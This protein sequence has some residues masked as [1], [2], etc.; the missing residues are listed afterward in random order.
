MPKKYTDYI[1]CNRLSPYQNIS[2]CSNEELLKKLIDN[3]N[4]NEWSRNAALKSLLGLVALDKLKRDEL[5]DYIRMLFH[6][7]LA[8]DEDFLTRLV[9]TASDIYPEELMQEINK[10]FE[11]NKVDTFCVDKAWINRMMAMS[12]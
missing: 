5:I 4:L 8:D 3:P 12:V 10:A 1:C 11:E 7:S 9:E 6:S 2:T